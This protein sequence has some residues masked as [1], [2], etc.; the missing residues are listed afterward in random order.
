MCEKLPFFHSPRWSEKALFCTIFFSP[1]IDSD[2]S[3]MHLG[4]FILVFLEFMVKKWKNFQHIDILKIFR[5]QTFLNFEFFVLNHSYGYLECISWIPGFNGKTQRNKNDFFWRCHV[6]KNTS[7]SQP[8]GDQKRHFF[9]QFVFLWI[10][11]LIT[12]RC[13]LGG[14]FEFFENLWCKNCKFSSTVTY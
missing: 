2:H 1:N 14:L 11:I 4:W 10:L 5:I 3:S 7:F 13:I 8:R 12:G 6:W 9:A